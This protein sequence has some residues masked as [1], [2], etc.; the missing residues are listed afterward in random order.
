MNLW[1]EELKSRSHRSYF[2]A[3]GRMEKRRR[4]LIVAAPDGRHG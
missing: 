4:G 1:V 2:V 3:I